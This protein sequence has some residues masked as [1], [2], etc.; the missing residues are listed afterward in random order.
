M[1]EAISLTDSGLIPGFAAR[2]ILDHAPIGIV[3]STPEWCC[4]SHL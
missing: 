4:L 2:D 3:T 1:P